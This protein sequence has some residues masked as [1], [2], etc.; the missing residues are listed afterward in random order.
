MIH[1]FLL[2]PSIWQPLLPEPRVSNAL[3]AFSAMDGH[4]FHAID[5]GNSY[6]I[7]DSEYKYRQRESFRSK[8]GLYW[9]ELDPDDPDFEQTGKEKML[10]GMDFPMVCMALSVDGYDKRPDDAT[11]SLYDF[12][13]LARELGNYFSRR[14]KESGTPWEPTERGELLIRSGCVTKVGYEGRGLMAALNHFV[15]LEAKA[16]AYRAISVGVGNPSIYRNW[17]KAPP[18]CRST[19]ISNVSVWDIELEDDEGRKVRPYVDSGM[20]KQGWLIWCD[21]DT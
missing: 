20:S 4:F 18:G 13:P 17:M 19:I 8:G 6:A 1:G 9:N 21:L 2:R 11:R 15:M 5:S 10:E 3:R 14:A 16:K 12:M 7:F